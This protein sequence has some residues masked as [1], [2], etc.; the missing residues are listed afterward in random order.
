MVAWLLVSW[1]ICW[2]GRKYILRL[3]KLS[4]IMPGA[5][6]SFILQESLKSISTT[7]TDQLAQPICLS[8][9]TM[10]LKAILI[11]SLTYLTTAIPT[12]SNRIARRG[13][14]CSNTYQAN[15]DDGPTC[16]FVTS[17]TPAIGPFP[18]ILRLLTPLDRKITWTR[19]YGP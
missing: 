6:T 5:S 15:Y 10:Q 3:C 12:A 2:V 4:I 1:L 17:N 14:D 7:C 13:P 16:N 8:A 19:S 11:L 9:S 18:F